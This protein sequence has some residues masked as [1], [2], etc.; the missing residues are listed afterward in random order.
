ML[1]LQEVGRF[2]NYPEE[3][4]ISS[5][6]SAPLSPSLPRTLSSIHVL[7]LRREGLSGMLTTDPEPGRAQ[8][9]RTGK[10]CN[11]GKAGCISL[12]VGSWR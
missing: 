5:L 3:P 10:R 2:Q 12:C 11:Q 4:K 7:D 9:L 1:E 6:H 8:Q